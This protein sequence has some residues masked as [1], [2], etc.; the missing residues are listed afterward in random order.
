MSAKN[1]NSNAGLAQISDDEQQVNG[2]RPRSQDEKKARRAKME[3]RAKMLK[4]E[5]M[6][7][8]QALEEKRG[9]LSSRDK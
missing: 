8:V 3:L 4:S 9:E 5:Y 6:G 1:T 7:K 2:R